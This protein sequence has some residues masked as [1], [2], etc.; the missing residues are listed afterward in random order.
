MKFT[1]VQSLREEIRQALQ[2]CRNSTLDLFIGVDRDT[3]CTQVHPDFSPIGWHLGHIAFTEAYWILEKCAGS[4]PVF[5]QY[6]KL[7]AADGLPKSDRQNLPA[8][9]VIRDYLETVRERVFTYLETAEIE[10]QER[11]WRWLIQ[12]ESQHSE[13]ISFVLQLHRFKKSNDNITL[14]LSIPYTP[15]ST[16]HTPEMVKISAGEFEMGRNSVEAQDNERPARLVYL[17]DYWIDRYPVSCSQYREF[18]NAGGY[19]N[20]QWWSE[21]GWKW[22]EENPVS[23]PLYWLDSSDWENHPVCGVS[24]YE[25]QAYAKFAD[26][27]LPTEAEW[28]KAASWNPETGKKQSYCW[29]ENKPSAKTCNHDNFVGHTTPV[30]AYPTGQSPSGCYDMLGNVWEWTASVFSGY[31][32]FES[33]PYTGY[34]EVYFDNQHKVLRGGSWATRPWGL[35]GSFRNWYHPGVRQIFAGFRC[36]N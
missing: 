15:Q 7:F 4:A 26:K 1:S 20:S 28:E 21:E 33:Y 19:E 2:T 23:Q 22:L 10:Q 6:H 8:L 11:L 18:I 29:G 30:N 35:R 36:A 25:A 13:T 14:N 27:R 5:S 24:W 16:T 9:E 17:D 12:H 3:F 34:S 31:E 32:N